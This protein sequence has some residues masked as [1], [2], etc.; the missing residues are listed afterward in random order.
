MAPFRPKAENY[1]QKLL[2]QGTK[3]LPDYWLEEYRANRIEF[4]TWEQQLQ[5]LR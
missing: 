4:N 2:K 3:S 1:S 5:P